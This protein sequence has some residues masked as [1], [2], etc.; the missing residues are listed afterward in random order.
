MKKQDKSIFNYIQPHMNLKP[1]IAY[2]SIQLKDFDF[3]L[4]WFA[5]DLGGS[6]IIHV[7][8]HNTHIML[9][10]PFNQFTT[11]HNASFSP[12]IRFFIEFQPGGLSRLIKPNVSDLLNQKVPLDDV[13]SY[14][15]EALKNIM[16]KQTQPKTVIDEIER[17]FLMRLQYHHDI[18]EQG[19]LVFTMLHEMNNMKKIHELVVESYYTHRHL[20]RFMKYFT[21]VSLKEYVVIKRFIDAI[22]LL[23]TSELSVED[24]AIELGYFDS[25]HFIKDFK[26]ISSITP[27][28]YRLNKSNFYNETMKQL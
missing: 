15:D 24:I 6:L 21:G 28:Q 23:K 16:V 10:G 8:L 12:I 26:R 25:A 2:Y 27:T 5:P 11:D 14:L 9:W 7:G 17:Y 1:Y 19:R 22:E 18:F 13:D 3:Q 20:N 4:P